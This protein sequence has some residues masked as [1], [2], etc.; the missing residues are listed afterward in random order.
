MAGIIRRKPSGVA[1]IDHEVGRLLAVLEEAGLAEDTLVVF[2]SEDRTTD[3]LLVV[4]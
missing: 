2:S 3:T 1:L 4:I